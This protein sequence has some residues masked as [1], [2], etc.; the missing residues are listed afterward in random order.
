MLKVVSSNNTF[1]ST[2]QSYLDDVHQRLPDILEDRILAEPIRR[3]TTPS[4]VWT[5][6]RITRFNPNASLLV[7]PSDQMI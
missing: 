1:I 2:N 4:V 3:N 5:A 7:T 6:Y